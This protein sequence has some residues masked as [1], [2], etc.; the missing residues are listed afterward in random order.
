MIVRERV[1]AVIQY[2]VSRSKAM[3]NYPGEIN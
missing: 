3:P 1:D 2:G